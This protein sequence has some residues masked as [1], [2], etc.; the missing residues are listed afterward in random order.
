M[1]Y[2]YSEKEKEKI[3]Q[4]EQMKMLLEQYGVSYCLP[5]DRNYPVSWHNISGMPAVLFYKG[6]IEIINTYKNVAVIGSRKASAKG[7]E[8]SYKTGA[9]VGKAGLNLVNGLALGCDTEAL[10]GSLAAGGRC[11]AILPCGLEQIQPKA[12]KE[13]AEEIL[14]KGGCLLSEYPIGTEP[15]RYRYVERDRL[16]SAVSQGVLVVEAEK[17]S[18]TMHTVNFAMKQFKRVACYHNRLL[19]FS[20]GN[21][22]LEDNGKVQILEKEEDVCE[23]LKKVMD[24][25][26]YEQMSF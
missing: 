15:Q 9:I 13:L 20:S 10:R 22:C 18:G 21:K 12:N 6:S 4:A 17:D 1:I 7:M 11:I 23:F 2:S 24:E 3:K 14:K 5:E 19:E 25:K 26:E 8:L 16:Q